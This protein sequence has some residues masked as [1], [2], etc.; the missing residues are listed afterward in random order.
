MEKNNTNYFNII[1]YVKSKL[2]P[3]VPKDEQVIVSLNEDCNNEPYIEITYTDEDGN[4]AGLTHNLNE[5]D[6]M[7][8]F[9]EQYDDVFGVSGDNDVVT[10]IYDTGT[11]KLNM[12][13]QK[14]GKLIGNKFLEDYE[15]A[16]FLG[17]IIRNQNLS[18]EEKIKKLYDEMRDIM[19][20]AYYNDY[21]NEFVF[22]TK[23]TELNNICAKKIWNEGFVETDEPEKERLDVE[24][25][26]IL[27][28]VF[29]VNLRE[30][31]KQ[32]SI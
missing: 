6:S 26:N 20:D 5:L 24:N 14:N 23:G 32:K 3:E 13:K 7:T 4:T 1:D 21:E 18:K 25:L 8:L 16:I 10:I 30:Q 28:E 19:N 11:S 27:E 29:G 15:T 9:I 17:Y 12:V 2:E 31:N 22:C